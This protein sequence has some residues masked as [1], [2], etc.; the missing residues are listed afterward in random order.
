METFWRLKW[1]PI[2]GPPVAVGRKYYQIHR[3]LRAQNHRVHR[4]GRAHPK[5][6]DCTVLGSV[7]SKL[8]SLVG[9]L[10]R[11][12]HPLQS[13]VS[14]TFSLLRLEC[15]S[16]LR[17][18]GSCSGCGT[19]STGLYRPAGESRAGKPSRPAKKDARQRT[20]VLLAP[21]AFYPYASFGSRSPAS[22]HLSPPLTRPKNPFFR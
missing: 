5:A 12:A 11:A 22:V 13:P 3:S 9:R 10:G 17:P 14:C 19:F 4:S 2:G 7:E 18:F 8:A 15:N 21:I 16:F 20:T 6:Y 1:V